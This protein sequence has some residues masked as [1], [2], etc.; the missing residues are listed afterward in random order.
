MKITEQQLLILI[1]VLEGSLSIHDRSDMNI[2]GYNTE[3][4]KQLY[5]QIMNNQLSTTL[6]EVENK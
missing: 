5:E 6:Y 1:R 2:F 4:R 3:F